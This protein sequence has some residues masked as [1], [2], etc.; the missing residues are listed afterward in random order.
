VEPVAPYE[1]ACSGGPGAQTMPMARVSLTTGVQLRGPE[2]AQRPRASSA[3]TS[4]LG[5][6][7]TQASHPPKWSTTLLPPCCKALKDVLRQFRKG[8]LFAEMASTRHDLGSGADVGSQ[9]M[10]LGL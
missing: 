10:E 1:E 8:V 6:T 2:G 5:S 7:E 9:G 4:E 3:S